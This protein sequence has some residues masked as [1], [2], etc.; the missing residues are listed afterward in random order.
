MFYRIWMKSDKG[1]RV[2]AIHG[3]VVKYIMKGYE[4][5]EDLVVLD[6]VHNRRVR[7]GKK[8]L[9]QFLA[10]VK[11]NANRYEPLGRYDTKADLTEGFISDVPIIG[12]TADEIVPVDESVHE[13][14]RLAAVPPTRRPA[15]RIGE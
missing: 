5:L 9:P 11:D 15:K 7:I 14:E 13:S 8:H 12:E 6:Q 10:A 2:R 4:L 3:N 1:Y